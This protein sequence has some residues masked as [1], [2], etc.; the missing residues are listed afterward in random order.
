MHLFFSNSGLYL[1]TLL[2]NLFLV[3]KLLS[4]LKEEVSTTKDYVDQ[5]VSYIFLYHGC[6]RFY[7]EEIIKIYHILSSHSF[8]II[9][10]Y[11]Y[12]FFNDSFPF[13]FILFCMC[14][15]LYF[16]FS[17]LFYFYARDSSS[18][19]MDGNTLDVFVLTLWR[20]DSFIFRLLFYPLALFHLSILK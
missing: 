3:V 6:N 17:F 12:V 10:C 18:L 4:N 5:L 15:Y 16:S 13:Y 9:L 8:H 2:V 1:I 20:Y 19:I 7:V 14:V 11:F